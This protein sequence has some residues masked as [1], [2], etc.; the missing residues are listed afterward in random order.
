MPNLESLA[1]DNK[2]TVEYCKGEDV[3]QA[4]LELTKDGFHKV[5]GTEIVIGKVDK[6]AA[7]KNTQNLE[8]VRERR[9]ANMPFRQ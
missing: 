2:V 9:L 6:N 3:Y 4:E 5:P 1:K 8:G 7:F